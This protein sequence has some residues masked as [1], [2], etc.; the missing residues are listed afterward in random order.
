MKKLALSILTIVLSGV[1]MVSSCKKETNN[2][3]SESQIKEE[4]L[5][6]LTIYAKLDTFAKLSVQHQLSISDLSNDGYC[7]YKNILNSNLSAEAKAE[8]FSNHNELQNLYGQFT[9]LKDFISNNYNLS[10]ALQI[11]TYQ[12]YLADKIIVEQGLGDILLVPN[13]DPCGNYKAGIR[14]CG[15]NFASCAVG[16]FATGGWAGFFIIGFCYAVHDDCIAGYD[17]Q[18]PNCTSLKSEYVN[19]R[20][21]MEAKNELD[22]LN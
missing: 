2:Q 20:G 9:E 8:M 1:L 21:K 10:S 18:F 17:R 19:F 3:I 15:L 22:C 16:A 12:E 11:N 5:S 13:V 7:D 14:S 6:P 4:A